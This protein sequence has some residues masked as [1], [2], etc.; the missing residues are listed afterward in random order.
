MAE[1]L[2]VS[3][4]HML[5]IDVTYSDE[6]LQAVAA[7]HGL[8]HME[9]ATKRLN[10]SVEWVL[11]EERKLLVAAAVRSGLLDLD[12]AKSILAVWKPLEAF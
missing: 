5:E 7:E 2:R 6:E 3:E 4:F 9:S 10:M 12:V 8:Q 11:Y 1:K